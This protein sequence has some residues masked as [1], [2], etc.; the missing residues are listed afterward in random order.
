MNPTLQ[1]VLSIFSVIVGL[2]MIVLVLLQNSKSE[3]LEAYGGGM[4]E[5]FFGKNKGRSLEAKLQKLTVG[6]AILF[7]LLT[8][9]LA[10]FS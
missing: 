7:F 3:G 4:G 10:L 5:T 9:V 6:A 2:V 8:A 1:L